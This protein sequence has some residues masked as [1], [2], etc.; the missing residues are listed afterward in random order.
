MGTG[1]GS[2]SRRA[3]ERAA[4]LVVESLEQR[5]LLSAAALD[6]TYGSG[7]MVQSD[8][9][10]STFD[11]SADAVQFQGDV[12]TAGNASGRAT[13]VAYTDGDVR[14]PNFGANGAVA[15][16]TDVLS[17]A[18]RLQIDGSGRILV[19]GSLN[20][21]AAVARFNADGS[22]DGSFGNN[23]VATQSAIGTNVT[24][25]QTDS[26]GDVI[27]SGDGSVSGNGNSSFALARF[28]D[29]GAVDT[30]FNGSGFVVDDRGTIHRSRHC[31]HRDG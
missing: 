4:F 3:V 25:V 11:T 12:L 9:Q 14:D 28:T 29:G 27:V 2:A 7:G 30:S 17:E 23:G 6:P 16:P 18:A 1:C 5:R 10:G 8:F 19:A 24:A 22:V 21:V 15:I 31:R 13:L 26:I 20:G